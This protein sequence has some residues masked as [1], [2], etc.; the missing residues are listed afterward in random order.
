MKTYI[1]FL[2]II[3]G[4]ILLS[5]NIKSTLVNSNNP[6]LNSNSFQTVEDTT[7]LDKKKKKKKKGKLKSRVKSATKS[8]KKLSGKETESKEKSN[9]IITEEGVEEEEEE[10]KK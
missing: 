10:K 9:L 6:D 2:A 7:K 4:F 8:A 1:Y 5:S 3:T